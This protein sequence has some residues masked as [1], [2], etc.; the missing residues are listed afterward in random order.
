MTIFNVMIGKGV[1][2]TRAIDWEALPATTQHFIIHYG[3]TQKLNDAH[4]SVPKDKPADVELAVDEMIDRLVE[5]TVEVRA[6]STRGDAVRTLAITLA[7]RFAPG[8][9]AKVKRA[10]AVIMVDSNAKW[11]QLARE[12]MEFAADAAEPDEELVPETEIDETE[13]AAA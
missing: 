1:N 12:T 5:G 3:L 2:A 13:T 11:L 4:A 10:N 8:K 9:D 7:T 6:A